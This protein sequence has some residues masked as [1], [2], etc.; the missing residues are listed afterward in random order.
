MDFHFLPTSGFP[1]AR[2]HWSGATV[3]T[4]M[5]PTL[6]QP[7]PAHLTLGT[8]L[9]HQR[10]WPWRHRDPSVAGPLSCWTTCLRS[11]C[12][13][14]CGVD[15]GY[16]APR[17]KSAGPGETYCLSTD[18]YKLPASVPG[19]NLASGPTKPSSLRN[20]CP[21]ETL[22]EGDTNAC[23]SPPLTNAQGGLP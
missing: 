7:L 16:C 3:P 17:V 6:Q 14:S 20:C 12:S 21:E 11:F 10:S 5:G 18:G 22:E 19:F 15:T 23:L 4:D 1:Q 13:H 8:Q 2:L 9:K